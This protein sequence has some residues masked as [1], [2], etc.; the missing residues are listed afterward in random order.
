VINNIWSDIKLKGN[1][2]CQKVKT[3]KTTCSAVTVPRLVFE[4]ANQNTEY[5]AYLPPKIAKY[6]TPD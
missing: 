2:L 5:I 3:N 4:S 6:I 1:K